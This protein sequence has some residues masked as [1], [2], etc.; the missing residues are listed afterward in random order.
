MVCGKPLVY[1]TQVRTEKCFYCGDKKPAYVVCLEGHFVCD[2]CHGQAVKDS[3]KGRILRSESSDPVALSLRWLEEYPFPMLG[4]EH[5]FLAAA[6]L[7]GGLRAAGLSLSDPEIEE[8]FHRTE[9]QA[10]GGFCGLTGICGIVP[11]LG[12]VLAYL[13]GSRCGTNREQREV[14]QF[15]GDLLHRFSELT[16][17]GCCK[18]YLW[19]GLEMAAQRIE[20]FFPQVRIRCSIPLCSFSDLHPHGCQGARCPYFSNP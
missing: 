6:A 11:A 12:A 8:I 20:E 14:M 18:A 10:R 5:A 2:S 7:L 4:C 3:L 9:A 15:T 17:P 19:A 16:G 13:T 1:R